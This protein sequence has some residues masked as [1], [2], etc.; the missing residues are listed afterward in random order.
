MNLNFQK[1]I[2]FIIIIVLCFPFSWISSLIALVIGMLFAIILG[3]PYQQESGKITKKLLQISI[4]G[5]GFGTSAINALEIGA[6]SFGLIFGF[7]ILT[8]ITGL[9]FGRIFNI[10]TK[11][12]H[13]ITS[14]TA[15]CGG[16]AIVAVSPV[17]KAN[18]KQMS[19]ALGTVFILS[20]LA[21]F[22]F[23]I[24]GAYFN[25]SEQQF[26]IW[27]AIAI[28]DTSSVLGA[29][30]DYGE[31]AL[32]VATTVKLGRV[33][34]IIPLVFL[35]AYFFKGSDA[36]YSF[37]YFI[38]LFLVA[39]LI[40]SIFPGYAE[41]FS[42]IKML[43]KKGLVITLFLIGANLSCK[44]LK[45]VGVKPFVQGFLL[46]LMISISSLLAILHLF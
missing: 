16:S 23:P 4:I 15:I 42:F 30:A 8:L 26:G 36:K 9:L 1:G 17:I 29:A 10:D 22:L 34:F 40:N 2:F 12:S 25:L 21:L 24:V 14:G 6:T 37:P 28:H 5:I 41:T 39:M 31:Q 43:A 32:E 45:S 19:V 27:A 35:E 44:N 33:L 38:V 13:L 46:W 3:N 7:I 11:I 20:A 18:E